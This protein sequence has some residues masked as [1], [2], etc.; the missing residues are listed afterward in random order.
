MKDAA[1]INK[2]NDVKCQAW[3]AFI[4]GVKNFLGDVNPHYKEI[5]EN[6]LEKLRVYGCNMSLKL[7]LLHSHLLL[8]PRQLRGFQ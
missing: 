4:E 7:H 3:N 5:V 8:L 1:F 6:M 2:M